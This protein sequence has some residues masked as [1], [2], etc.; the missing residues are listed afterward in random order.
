M[1]SEFESEPGGSEK[2]VRNRS[3]K[4][5]CS[6][7]VFSPA[8]QH[9]VDENYDGDWNAQDAARPLNTNRVSA[10][11]WGKLMHGPLEY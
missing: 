1:G 3:E 4:K 7:A 2:E 10:Q 9:A 11:R 6:R 5:R 8:N